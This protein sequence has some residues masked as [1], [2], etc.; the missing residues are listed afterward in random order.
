M[1][2]CRVRRL[3]T[4]FFFTPSGQFV[5][6]FIETSIKPSPAASE[7]PPVS[8]RVTMDISTT[9]ERRR[10]VSSGWDQFDKK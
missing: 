9:K 2:Q 8:R 5:P 4:L 1:S 3:T 7:K 6:N 10:K